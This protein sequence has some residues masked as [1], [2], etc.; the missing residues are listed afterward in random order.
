MFFAGGSP[1]VV[2]GLK[3]GGLRV[4]EQFQALPV[5]FPPLIDGHDGAAERREAAKLFLDILEPFVPLSM[6]YLLNG[7]IA[8]MAT[9]LFVLFV[10]FRDFRPQVHDFFLENSE[11]IHTIRIYQLAGKWPQDVHNKQYSWFW[12]D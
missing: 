2:Q 1:S 12:P 4:L 5:F 11:M 9:I 6:S 10:N 3:L 7:S 8:L